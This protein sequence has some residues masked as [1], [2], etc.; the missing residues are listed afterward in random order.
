M[1]PNAGNLVQTP[2]G[3]TR[4]QSPLPV[5]KVKHGQMG[6]QHAASSAT[7]SGL[8]SPLPQPEPTL[9]P[10]DNRKRKLLPAD[11]SSS[12][13]LPNVD[14]A[15]GIV[16]DMPLGPLDRKTSDVPAVQPDSAPVSDPFALPAGSD[17]LFLELGDATKKHTQIQSTPQLSSSRPRRAVNAEAGKSGQCDTGVAH[18]SYLQ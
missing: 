6:K 15:A 7:A 13:P 2:V 14:S 10:L 9:V 3:S 8:N 12:P 4:S 17:K 11:S 16:W 1:T 18:S 5:N